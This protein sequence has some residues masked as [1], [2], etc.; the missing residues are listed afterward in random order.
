MKP[1]FIALLIVSLAA[2]IFGFYRATEWLSPKVT[3]KNQSNMA[4]AGA[5]VNLPS[6]TLSFDAIATGSSFTILRS[7]AQSDGTYQYVITLD[8]GSTLV[9]NCGYVTNSEMAITQEIVVLPDNTV[10]CFYIP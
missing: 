6:N 10:E 8:D 5:V 1:P 3:I 4:I 9:G 7:S 2:L